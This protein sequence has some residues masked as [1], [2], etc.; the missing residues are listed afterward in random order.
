VILN[1]SCDGCR[2]ELG[3]ALQATSGGVGGA[4]FPPQGQPGQ[5]WPSSSLPMQYANFMAPGAAG[6]VHPGLF[7]QMP[8]GMQLPSGFPTNAQLAQV[9]GFE[10]AEGGFRV[11]QSPRPCQA[12]LHW[13]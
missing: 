5:Q 13:C 10:D 12:L 2:G 1:A 4:G 3:A 7:A 8:Q 11:V 9:G 6:M